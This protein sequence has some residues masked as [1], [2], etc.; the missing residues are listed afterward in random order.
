MRTPLRSS[1]TLVLAGFLL[2]IG[3]PL[4]AATT[5]DCE[6]EWSQSDSAQWC[7]L[8]SGTSIQNPNDGD[9]AICT[10]RITCPKPDTADLPQRTTTHTLELGC[11]STLYVVND[12]MDLGTDCT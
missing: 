1:I 9:Q 4:L 7:E 11:V 8:S 12:Q 3:P 10:L 2:G 5:S 6:N